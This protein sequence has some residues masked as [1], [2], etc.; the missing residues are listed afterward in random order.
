MMMRYDACFSFS[1][2]YLAPSRIS[3]QETF[4]LGVDGLQRFALLR[5]PRLS[6]DTVTSDATRYAA[7]GGTERC[8]GTTGG[9]C[10]EESVLKGMTLIIVEAL[11]MI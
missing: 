2:G 8:R 7:A 6:R 10:P 11:A 5:K 1:V 9:R 3:L 4:S